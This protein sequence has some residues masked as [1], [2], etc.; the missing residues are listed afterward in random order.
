MSMVS[1]AHS[2]GYKQA[3]PMHGQPHQHAFH[4]ARYTFESV[5][6]GELQQNPSQAPQTL[7]IESVNV[8]FNKI[9]I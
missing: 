2:Q 3:H 5:T 8:S 1:K 4:M 9:A 7:V 6:D